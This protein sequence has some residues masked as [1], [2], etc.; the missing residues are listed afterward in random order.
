VSR[1]AP[2]APDPDLVL[3][4]DDDGAACDSLACLIE[5]SGFRAQTA[6]SAE[7]VLAA[8]V[9]KDACCLIVDVRLGRGQDG[10]SLV[11]SLRS[12]GDRR[13]VIIV[14]GHGDIPLAVRAMRAGASDFV[15]KPFSAE[16]ILRAVQDARSD[17]AELARGAALIGRLTVRERDVL[18]GLVDGKGNKVIAGDLGISVRTVE[19][20][21]ASIMEKLGVRS[22][23]EA[24]R[25]AVLTGI[26]D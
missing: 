13:P 15:E 25:I 21:R 6:S 4:V 18:D 17:G 24:V 3:V 11:E 16:R 7:E 14:T 10:I 23:A 5:A 12:A 8:G 2:K 26:A 9:P 22:F 19:A 1:A 20:Y